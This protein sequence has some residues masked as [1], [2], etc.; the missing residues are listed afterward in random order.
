M[1]TIVA[2]ANEYWNL[3]LLIL[4]GLVVAYALWPGRKRAKEMKDAANI[5]LQDDT[6]VSRD[7]EGEK[8]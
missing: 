8:K 1:D 7:D 3:W 4:F 2:L 5:P 6:P